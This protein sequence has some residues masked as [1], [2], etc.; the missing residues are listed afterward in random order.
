MY[1]PKFRS[2]MTDWERFDESLDAKLDVMAKDAMAEIHAMVEAAMPKEA[3]PKPFDYFA[4][5]GQSSP[6]CSLNA[7][8]LQSQLMDNQYHGQQGAYN[9]IVTLFG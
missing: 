7:A 2:W 3:E 8:Q 1:A 4:G 6:Y 9:S 5:L